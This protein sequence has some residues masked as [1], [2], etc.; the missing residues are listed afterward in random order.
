MQKEL[1]VKTRSSAGFPLRKSCTDLAPFGQPTPP[2]YNNSQPVP[3][4]EII[5]KPSIYAIV[6]FWPHPLKA[7]IRVRI[8]VS[9]PKP[10]K[11]RIMNGQSRVE[12]SEFSMQPSYNSPRN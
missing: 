11:R 6:L 12:T 1:Q 3:D 10:A 4:G 9:L 7:E 8:P 2:T 5:K